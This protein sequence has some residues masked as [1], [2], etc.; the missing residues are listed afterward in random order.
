VTRL[1]GAPAAA[2]VHGRDELDARRVKN[3]VVCAG[4]DQRAGLQRLTQRVY[5]LRRKFRQLVE[6][7][8]AVMG[9]R[10]LSRA[11]AHAAA[12]Q[13]RHAGGVMRRAERPLPAE[14]AVADLPGHAL[15][16]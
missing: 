7:Q 8:H 16:H 5:D 12:D 15:D 10:H 14:L 4:D 9:Q 3:S 11:R 13:R 1:I 6:E 2:G